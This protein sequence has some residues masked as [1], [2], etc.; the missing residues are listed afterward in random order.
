MNVTGS[1]KGV[2]RDAR[3]PST[4]RSGLAQDFGC[5]LT[6]TPSSTKAVLDGDP[7]LT[8]AKRLNFEFDSH[9]ADPSVAG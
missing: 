7:E 8:P 4:R 6:F 2:K 9:D 3:A 5:G 1:K